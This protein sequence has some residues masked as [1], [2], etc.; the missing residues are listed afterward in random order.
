MRV[1]GGSWE[2]DRSVC[3][4]QDTWCLVLLTPTHWTRPVVWGAI[5]ATIVAGFGINLLILPEK[6]RRPSIQWSGPTGRFRG[7]LF[8][9]IQHGYYQMKDHSVLHPVSIIY[10]PSRLQ[11]R[12]SSIKWVYDWCWKLY[13][14]CR[15]F[16]TKQQ[17]LPA[18]VSPLN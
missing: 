12:G 1:R 3:W 15:C 18:M 4:S 8:A 11:P 5:K 10:G 16:T 2:S 9:S 13:R 7:F 14:L 6:W 17:L